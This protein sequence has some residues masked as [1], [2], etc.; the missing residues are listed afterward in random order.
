VRK[1]EGTRCGEEEGDGTRL[2]GVKKKEVTE[3]NEEEGG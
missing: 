1:K 2:E 3:C